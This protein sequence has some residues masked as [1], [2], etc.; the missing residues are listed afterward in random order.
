LNHLLQVGYPLQGG[1]DHLVSE[2]LYLADPDGNGI[3]IY[4]DRPAS[5]W[6]WRNGEVLMATDPIDAEGGYQVVMNEGKISTEDPSG[7]R[8]S[9]EIE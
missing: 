7:N 5:T 9:L 8:I 2:A 6:K 4:I 1:S 3:E